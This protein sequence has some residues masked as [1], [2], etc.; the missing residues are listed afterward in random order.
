M[1]RS[2]LHKLLL[3]KRHFELARE[4]L[5]SA[6][7]LSLGIGVNLLQ[8]A[9]EV[10]LL[11]VAEHVGAGIKSGTNFDSYFDLIN[12]KISPKELPFRSRLLA[13][14]KLRVNS[15]HYGLAPA[16]SETDGLLVTCREF[17]DE[18]TEGVLGL[19]FAT[20]SL[21]DLIRDGEA[22]ELLREAEEVF[23]S[24]DFETCLIN[25]RKAL[26]VRI[27]TAYDILP[28]IEQEESTGFGLFSRK[29]PHYARNKDYVAKNVKDAT[30][31]IVLDHKELDMDL[32]KSGIDNVS[33]WNIWRLTPGV[34]RPRQGTEW[35]VKREFGKF[36]E[37]GIEDRAEY[38][39]NTTINLFVAADQ[40][41]ASIKAS[42]PRNYFITLRQDQNPV[43][44]KADL[45]SRVVAA[46]PPGL[47]ELDVDFSVPAL[48]GEGN[49]WHVVHFG[50][51][52]LVVGYIHENAVKPERSA[53]DDSE[54]SGCLLEKAHQNVF[55]LTP[56]HGV[57]GAHH[58]QIANKRRSLG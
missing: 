7:E 25:C 31:Y 13:L 3:A 43:Y 50:P 34:Y 8:D 58:A 54:S 39:L 38:V 48:Q 16:K 5:S 35:V 32:M 4:N 22:K 30:D 1:N 14:N 11:A 37:E 36:D 33:F 17:F 27:E 57:Y 46:T 49:F 15:K 24:G 41:L 2:M 51:N 40:K 44:E 47:T 10:F 45:S 6:N 29:S 19:S 56:N 21:I 53:S 52:E 12:T 20:V 42:V 18:V 23:T 28:F 26:F 9:V 55:D